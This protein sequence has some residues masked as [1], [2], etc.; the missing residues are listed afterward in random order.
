[1]DD[2]VS[3]GPEEHV[4]SDFE[5]MK[6]SLYF[7]DLV[8]L[9]H[10]GD[11]VNF[12]GLEITKTRKGF[13]VK[14]ST[15]LAESLLNLYGL[16]NSKP[17]VN[18]GRRLTVMELASATSL[19]GHDYSNFRTAVGKLIFMAP[20]RPDMT[21]VHTSSQLHDREQARSETV[22]TIS[23]RH[24]THL[25][26]VL[27]RAKWFQQ[28]CWK[29][30]GRSDS[31][32]AGD[33][34]TRQSVTGYHCDVQNVTM[35]N[36]SLKQTAI[37]FSSC[38]AQFYTASACVRELLGLAEL[39]KEL[40]YK[41]SVRLEMDSDSARHILQRRGPGGLK[42][43]EIRCLSLHQWTREKR[44]SVSCVDTKNN[45][46]DLFTKHLDGLRTRALAKKLRLRFLDMAGGTNMGTNV[47]AADGGT[48][49]ED[50]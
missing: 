2:V 17:S 27:N 21:T 48:N 29:L 13:E 14:N 3:I 9:R 28:V 16:Q 31:D 36:R 40:H 35:C 8:V 11:T 23:Q 49:E 41:V 10:E 46:A 47:G 1:M 26:F 50:R 32:W 15:D 43:I 24:A 20:W 37:S 4:M 7:T 39:F 33:S 22:D 42:H 44:L 25:F 12:L 30:V 5:H 38:E 18:P 6:T 34:P 19:D 45:T